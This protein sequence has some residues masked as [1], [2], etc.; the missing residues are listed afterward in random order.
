MLNFHLS[1]FWDAPKQDLIVESPF[2]CNIFG[3]PM[4]FAEVHLCLP[5]IKRIDDQNLSVLSGRQLSQQALS[6]HGRDGLQVPLHIARLPADPS[7]HK[8]PA[9]LSCLGDRKVGSSR[10]LS[11][12]C[13]M[14]AGVQAASTMS[15]PFGAGLSCDLGGSSGLFSASSISFAFCAMASMK[16]LERKLVRVIFRYMG[17]PGARFFGGYG[18]F[19]CTWSRTLHIKTF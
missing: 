16:V 1:A 17:T 2:S 4:N 11:V 9:R 13:L 8:L 19:L 15:L 6:G 12:G 3:Y 10:F 14:S 18:V 5:P 7:P